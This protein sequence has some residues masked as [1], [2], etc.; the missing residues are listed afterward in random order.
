MIKYDNRQGLKIIFTLKG[1]VVKNVTPQVILCSIL[2]FMFVGI[3]N[4]I[5]VNINPTPWAIVGGALGLLLVFRTN[6][7]YDRY[8]EGRKLWGGISNI[9]KNL[10]LS[11]LA[12]FNKNKHVDDKVKLKMINLI[13]A[14]PKMAK[15]L[16]RD[17]NDFSEI[18]HLNKFL[19]EEEIEILYS[20]KNV[21][22]SIVLM[23]KKVIYEYVEKDGI[24][25]FEGK[26]DDFLS[27]LGGCERILRNPIPIAY[28][29]HLKTLLI[30]FCS[31]LTFAI[32]SSMGWLS[33]L[34]IIFVSFA[35]LGIEEIGVEIEDPFGYDDN[36][37]PL[38]DICEGIEATVL[39]IYKQYKMLEG[40]GIA[41]E[42][43]AVSKN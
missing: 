17:E 23:L 39:G 31:T 27:M 4:I 1:S 5:K 34:V 25:S 37:L 21:P 13:I 3:H 15:Q 11:L 20:S 36:D 7:A 19:T 42:E 8:W 38:D 9:S 26:L 43:V 32:A 41:K 2:S 24:I 14:F 6:T 35:F 33:I 29:V 16:L 22:V 18:E 10:A 30:L 12:Y 28:V 40:I